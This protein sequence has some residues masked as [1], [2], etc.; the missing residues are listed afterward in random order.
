MHKARLFA[1]FVA[2]VVATT[3]TYSARAAEVVPGIQID[4]NDWTF[5][6]TMDGPRVESFLAL[7][8][9][10]ETVDDNVAAVWFQRGE[11]TWQA[12]AWTSQNLCD[13]ISYVKQSLGISD[14]Y[15][16]IWPVVGPLN[17][18]NPPAPQDFANGLFANDP[19]REMLDSQPDQGAFL[20]LLVELGY[21]AAAVP[22][23]LSNVPGCGLVDPSDKTEIATIIA[24]GIEAELDH[25][26]TRT[27]VGIALAENQMAALPC[28]C[29]WW[30]FTSDPTVVS[31]SCTWNPSTGCAWNAIRCAMICDYVGTSTVNYTR[32]KQRRYVCGGTNCN[33]TETGTMT[34][35][36]HCPNTDH[37]IDRD[38][39]N[40]GLGYVAPSGPDCECPEPTDIIIWNILS[41]C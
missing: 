31:K 2:I 15:D 19:M 11:D 27:G 25:S 20:E 24:N 7:K 4:M 13:A 6:P 33:W 5:V 21:S 28:F 10:G 36:V 17:I 26:P 16:D 37:F 41:P 22:I 35:T 39:V 12:S 23:Q 38:C 18:Q 29:I 34:G 1:T 3:F 40:P 9:R 30:T 14:Q 32:T 8:T